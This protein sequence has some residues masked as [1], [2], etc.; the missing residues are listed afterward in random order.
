M[1]D[2]GSTQVSTFGE[3]LRKKREEAGLSL[4]G[5]ADLVSY[6]PGWVSKIENGL[7]SP[8]LQMARLCDNKLSAGGELIG[9]VQEIPAI[10]QRV[11]P[12][13]Q[14]PRDAECV[15]GRQRELRILNDCLN[16]STKATTGM[17][18]SIEGG[19]GTG[20]TSL[21]VRWAHQ[22]A[23]SFGGGTLF[24]DLQGYSGH[25]EP[26]SA[27]QVLKDFL[28]TLGVDSVDIP[29]SLGQRAA[30]FRTLTARRR[31]L[32]VLDNAADYPQV[33][34]LLPGGPG[35]AVVVTSRR[36]LMELAVR[37]QAFTLP[38]GPLAADDAVNVLRSFVGDT[39]SSAEAA[40][41]RVLARQCGYVPLA[42]R[43]AG[44]RLATSRP[45]QE[46]IRDLANPVTRLDLLSDAKDIALSVRAALERSYR[47]LDKSAAR[48]FRL[49]GLVPPGLTAPAAAALSDWPM[50]R[51]RRALESLVDIHLVHYD[52]DGRYTLD[53]LNSAF[54]AERAFA[55]ESAKEC[56]TAMERL[57]DWLKNQSAAMTRRPLVG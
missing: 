29:A 6:S 21:A 26:V 17:L 52:G 8:T 7:G 41:S 30:F 56:M 33:Q 55:E 12:P 40:A 39:R 25:H 54:A 19:V 57:A 11:E 2:M 5:F 22:V 45:T 38:V 37:D 18:V 13:F 32:V 49:F 20:K 10:R 48:M 47:D 27:K 42:L 51:S 36:R 16:R 24:A 15:I 43:I 50:C 28:T 4:R 3:T 34:P 53:E 14:L 46:L 44:F 23:D 1:I 35:C 31:V 9:L